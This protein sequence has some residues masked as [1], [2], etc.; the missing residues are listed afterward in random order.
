MGFL[1]STFVFGRLLFGRIAFAR[2][3]ITLLIISLLL[4]LLFNLLFFPT[5]YY[6]TEVEVSGEVVYS[7]HSNASYSSVVIK[8]D[9]IN[10]KSDTHRLLITGAKDE[11]SGLNVGDIL[12]ARLK[13]LPLRDND[14]RSYYLSLGYCARGDDLR[15]VNVL[16]HDSKSFNGFFASIRG[17][18]CDRLRNITNKRTGDFLSA[19][20][21]G[22][23][24][25]LAPDISLSFSRT[26]TTH[27]LALSG[28]HLVILAYA[29][30]LVLKLFRMNKRLRT[31][32]TALAVAFYVPFTGLS[33]SVTRAGVMVLISSLIFLLARRSD[34]PTTL[35]LS[36]FFIIAAEPYAIYDIA[37]WL[38]ALAT[39]GLILLSTLLNKRGKRGKL[40]VRAAKALA[41]ATLASVFA[42]SASMIISLFF[43]DEF[44]VLALPATLVLSILTEV[45]IYLSLAALVIGKIIPFG[46][47]IIGVSELTF[48]ITEWFSR[49]EYALVPLD[50]W[51]VRILAIVL[52][53]AFFYLLVFADRRHRKISILII[54]VVFILINTAGIVQSAV[55]KN[56]DK[57]LFYPDEGC[58]LIT[59][60]SSGE[61]SI[62]ASGGRKDNVYD[63]INA[64]KHAKITMVDRLI[65]P[66]YT[67]YTM[68]MVRETVSELLVKKLILPAPITSDE[69]DYALYIAELLSS[70]DTELDFFKDGEEILLGD[71][72][73]TV[74]SHSQPSGEWLYNS[75]SIIGKGGTMLYLSADCVINGYS[76]A[77]QAI[78]TADT[79]I[80]GGA[81]YA[82]GKMLSLMPKSA[83]RV[84]FGSNFKL[85]SECQSFFNE[86]GVSV[87]FTDTPVEIN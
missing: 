78:H 67:Y 79:V 23:R 50:F 40:H 54:T 51:I 1:A 32:F 82:D 62:I 2:V 35:S 25:V 55:V 74:H 12:T 60:C 5:E 63:V 65:I 73:L 69:Y 19:L 3:C 85:L 47:L 30:S 17:S 34:G 22:E 83:K 15:G 64:A 80:I 59:V 42:I 56:K 87:Q 6:D 41:S 31:V 86:K 18:V 43:F 66:S 9:K 48:N 27:I 11:L 26:G 44:S 24:V 84:I 72:C 70:F 45:L 46:R 81:K 52:I 49:F 16:E 33:A 75:F 39:L 58:N 28:A 71:S 57:T 20:L 36:I 77:I 4:G 13:I 8:T 21:T 76:P 53:G 29:V 37:L 38:S 68:D 61:Y 7:D 14:T 10:E